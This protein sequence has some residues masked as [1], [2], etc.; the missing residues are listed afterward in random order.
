MDRKK[1]AINKQ[2]FPDKITS[3][4]KHPGSVFLLLI[5]L[6]AAVLT[7]SVLVFLVGYILIRG[8]P[9]LKPSLF[10]LNYNSDNVSMLPAMVNTL[11]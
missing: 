6:L 7:V 11:L 4:L 8:I 9:Y 5:V 2:S 10:A 1:A 3:Y